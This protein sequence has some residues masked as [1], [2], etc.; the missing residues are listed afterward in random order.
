MPRISVVAVA[1]VLGVWI[2]AGPAPEAWVYDRHAVLAGEWWR[3][4]TGHLV[5]SDFE[6]LAWNS[7]GLLIL[8]ILF[9][10]ALKKDVLWILGIGVVSV[11]LFLVIDLQLARYCGLSGVLNTLLS[12]GLI[13]RMHQRREP[14][15]A[16]T[17][18][19]GDLVKIVCEM[20]TGDALFTD[21]SWSSVPGAHLFGLAGGLIYAA[22][23]LA[24]KRTRNRIKSRK[25]RKVT[26]VEEQ[27]GIQAGDI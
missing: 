4:L 14:M 6:H 22:T 27:A 24:S 19:L 7:A 26:N 12:A 10:P 8:G 16:A 25:K 21:T 11:G 1:V 13:A 17:I 2:V 3:L 23:R 15:I 9:E 20:S 18:L 5:H